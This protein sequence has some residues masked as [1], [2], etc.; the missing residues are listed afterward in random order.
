MEEDV[1]DALKNLYVQAT[2]ERSHHYAGRTVERAIKE[3]EF[4]REL[5]SR[6][7]IALR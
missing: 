3:I 7:G 6:A 5:M 2:K 4:L 1:L